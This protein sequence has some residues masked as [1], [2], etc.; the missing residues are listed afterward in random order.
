MTKRIEQTIN[1]TEFYSRLNDL[2]GEVTRLRKAGSSGPLDEVLDNFER[3]VATLMAIRTL[4]GELVELDSER[5]EC[6][7]LLQAQMT[8]EI[9]KLT[10]VGKKATAGAA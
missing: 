1:K 7:W 6:L 8:T 10:L 3:L 9:L 5:A 4:A 2:M